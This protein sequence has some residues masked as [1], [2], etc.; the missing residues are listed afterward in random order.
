MAICAT[1][2]AVFRPISLTVAMTLLLAC[3]HRSPPES[4]RALPTTPA[5]RQAAVAGAPRNA[6]QLDELVARV[7]LY[8]DELL[9]LVLPASTQPTQIVEAA[10]FLEA[11][12]RDPQL[13]PDGE[14][15]RSPSN[16]SSTTPK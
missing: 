5:V 6:E 11:R 2:S 12:K 8:P 14:L 10:R 15:G 9:A 1:L 4:L 16:R 3:A 7:A 13:T